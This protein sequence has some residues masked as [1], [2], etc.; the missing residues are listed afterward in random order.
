[1]EIQ[2]LEM[3]GEI[4][5]AVANEYGDSGGYSVRSAVCK[6]SG[7][8]YTLYQELQTFGAHGVHAIVHKGGSYLVFV[9]NFLDIYNINSFVYKLI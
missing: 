3:N 9:N 2:P 6:A 4:F 8:Q 1:M 5:L 7:A